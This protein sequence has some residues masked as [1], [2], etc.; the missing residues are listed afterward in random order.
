M[1]TLTIEVH[2]LLPPDDARWDSLECLTLEIGYP[3]LNGRTHWKHIGRV[4]ETLPGLTKSFCHA[5]W[6]QNAANHTII[7]DFPQQFSPQSG[8]PVKSYCYRTRLMGMDGKMRTTKMKIVEGL[9][10]NLFFSFKPCYPGA[11]T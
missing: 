4:Q 1:G 5:L 3:G 7:F 9:H 2:C 11:N 6:S 8:V 10:T